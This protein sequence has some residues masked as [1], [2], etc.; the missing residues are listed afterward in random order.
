MPICF[1][2]EV[3][4]VCAPLDRLLYI[5]SGGQAAL[6]VILCGGPVPGAAQW[7]PKSGDRALVIGHLTAE[8]YASVALQGNPSTKGDQD[9]LLRLMN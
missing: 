2:S 7:L 4:G 3:S 1:A 9:R 6:Q 5:C 8:D